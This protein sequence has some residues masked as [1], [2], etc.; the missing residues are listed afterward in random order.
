MTGLS[1]MDW[2]FWATGVISWFCLWAL[3]LGYCAQGLSDRL[4]RMSRIRRRN[5]AVRA[6]RARRDARPTSAEQHPSG[7]IETWWR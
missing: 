2:V 5:R 6:A 1:P 3:M 4:K 7:D